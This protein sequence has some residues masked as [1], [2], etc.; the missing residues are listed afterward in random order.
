[1]T[2]AAN[3]YIV[4]LSPHVIREVD[5]QHQN[6][7]LKSL[8]CYERIGDLAVNIANEVDTLR[9]ENRVFS[10]TAL[11]EL[12]IAFD[13]I[14]EILALTS[15]AYKTKNTYIA[16][17][18]EP[19]E[20]VIDDLVEDLNG[21]HVYRMTNG[22][23][24]PIN[25]IRYQAILTNVEHISDKCSDIAIYIME[26]EDSSIFGQE[27]SF[28][29]ELHHSASQRYMQAY[30]D[31]YSKYFDALNAIPAVEDQP[32]KEPAAESSSKDISKKEKKEQKEK[33]KKDKKSR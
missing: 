19:L 11:S 28:V 31:D 13:A 3:K 1:M 30:S 6:R 2:D 26:G 16:R 29:H 20:E 5:N 22:L 33:I 18:V 14:Y 4:S 21:R 12:R 8:I 10:D 24:D 9:S 27:H 32:E 25:G 23:C 17:K 15:E 7:V